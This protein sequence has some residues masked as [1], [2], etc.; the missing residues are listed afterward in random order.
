VT[1]SGPTE[2]EHEVDAPGPGGVVLV[3]GDVIDD[4]VVRSLA[5]TQPDTDTPAVITRVPGGAGANQAVWL[6]SCGADVRFVGCVGRADVDRHTRLLEEAGVDA[7]LATDPQVS[8]G[9]IVA[10]VDPSG[11]RTMYSDRGANLR[12]CEEHLEDEGFA[13]LLDDVG[14]VLVS[15]YSL[16]HQRP[17]SVA[18][19]LKD[20][21]REAGIPVA[22][23]PA[24]VGFIREVGTS[25]FLGWL[26]G[27]SIVLPNLAEG[28]LL[29]MATGVDDV[30]DRLL[31]RFAVVA[32]TLG[33]DGVV[34]AARDG[35]RAT[36]AAAMA[37]VVDTTGAGDAF[38]GGFLAAWLRGEDLEAAGRAGV[39]PA[40]RVVA[41]PGGRFGA[42]PRPDGEPTP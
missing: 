25:S 26:D 29:T 11:R 5:T 18:L 41:G 10:I 14:L 13:D 30:V 12:L 37:E 2:V 23:D 40:A 3:V 22:V 4:V 15:G 28:Q 24:S 17:R 20:R 35:V 16:C 39:E 8:T 27:V 21:A 36:I 9:R 38:A 31:D 34:V 19:D 6:A 42:G 1:G 33:P 7:R 32:V